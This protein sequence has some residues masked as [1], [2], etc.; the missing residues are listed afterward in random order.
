MVPEIN[1]TDKT[2]EVTFVTPLVETTVRGSLVGAK[3]IEGATSSSTVQSVS[4]V[5]KTLR[6]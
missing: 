1:L 3:G 4:C 5:A 2:R 6:F